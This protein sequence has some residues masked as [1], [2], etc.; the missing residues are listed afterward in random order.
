MS[1]G[2]EIKFDP[3]YEKGASLTPADVARVRDTALSSDLL[4]GRLV[5]RAGDVAG[6]D[7]A[8]SDAAEG[9]ARGHLRRHRRGAEAGGRDG[10]EF[11]EA[12]IRLSGGIIADIAFAEAAKRDTDRL[13]PIMIALIFIILAIGYRSL[14]GTLITMLVVAVVDRRRL[15]IGGWLGFSLNAATA[16]APIMIMVLSIAHCVHLL[17]NVSHYRA[18]GYAL[19]EAIVHTLDVNMA[20]III[21][22]LTTVVGFARAEFQRIAALTRAGEHRGDGRGGRPRFQRDASASASVPAANF[23]RGCSWT[24]ESRSMLKLANFTIRYRRA[25]LWVFAGLLAALGG[26]HLA[27]IDRRQHRRVFRR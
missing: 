7:G 1:N 17:T 15:G 5:S 3:L 25:L 19:D 6:R 4:V 2:E 10:R 14:T 18:E 20:P 11:P 21:T 24:A 9:R 8:Y 22:T 27:N 13:V 16:G 12:D 23:W 26:R